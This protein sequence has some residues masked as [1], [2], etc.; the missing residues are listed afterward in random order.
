MGQG[1][2]RLAVTVPE[3]EHPVPDKNSGNLPICAPS[4]VMMTSASAKAGLIKGE[5]LNEAPPVNVTSP[6]KKFSPADIDTPDTAEAGPD[7][8]ASRKA[9]ETKTR[10]HLRAIVSPIPRTQCHLATPARCRSLADRC[11]RPPVPPM[12]TLQ[13]PSPIYL[14]TAQRP[15]SP[16]SETSCGSRAGRRR[17]AVGGRGRRALRSPSGSWVRRR[18]TGRG[19]C[20]RSCGG[21]DLPA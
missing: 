9:T 12:A 11:V 18:T 20:G 15:W 19:R 10:V 5:H 4:P 17:R 16:S 2:F 6:K 7:V 13:D 21:S 1:R 3:P 14:N 8:A